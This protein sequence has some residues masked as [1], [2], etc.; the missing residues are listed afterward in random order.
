MYMQHDHKPKMLL[1][2][3]R[4]HNIIL[5]SWAIIGKLYLQRGQQ[6]TS[7]N[8]FSVAHHD[9]ALLPP[10]TKIYFNFTIAMPVESTN[11]SFFVNGRQKDCGNYVK[12]TRKKSFYSSSSG[13]CCCWNSFFLNLQ[14]SD[15]EVI[16]FSFRQIETRQLDF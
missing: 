4:M 12:A 1:C 16:F 5:T 15:S 3:R 6:M 9:D 11:P 2:L 7:K 8:F 10:F 14:I 13:Q